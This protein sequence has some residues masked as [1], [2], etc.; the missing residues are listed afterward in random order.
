MTLTI[1][2]TPAVRGYGDG[3]T[4]EFLVVKLLI[5]QVKHFL[6]FL[7]DFRYLQHSCVLLKIIF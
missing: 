1:R 4:G 6:G 3:R 5:E 7:Y 2:A